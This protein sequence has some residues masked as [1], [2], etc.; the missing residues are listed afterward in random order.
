MA[1]RGATGGGATAVGG[2]GETGAGGG[3][4]LIGGAVGGKAMAVGGV[5]GPRA[6]AARQAGGLEVPFGG[7]S[8]KV[9]V[10]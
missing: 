3:A 7:A 8:T 10:L 6:A 2:A 9:A 1:T 4:V 5:T